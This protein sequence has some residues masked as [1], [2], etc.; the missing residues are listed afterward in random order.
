[1]QSSFSAPHQQPLHVA[2]IMDG[3]GRWATSRRLPREAG[4][5]AGARAVR[6]VV[7]AAHRLGIGTLTLFAFSGDNWHR[8]AREVNH[9]L[10][11]F[12]DY[13]R[14]AKDECVDH[15]I[16][17]SVVGRRDRFPA[18]LLAAAEVAEAATAEG[19]RMRLRI[20]LDYSGRDAILRAAIRLKGN[21]APTPETFSKL[22]AEATNAGSPISDVDLLIR[23]GGEQ[24][25]SDFM[26]WECAYA[27][28][29]FTDR[30]WPDFEAVDLEEALQEF[31]RRER[32]F[33]RI[34]EAVAS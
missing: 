34:S 13:L 23:T 29:I 25:L 7:Q 9:L 33:G 22:L 4:H 21:L 6:G 19:S 5:R 32:R 12:E 11:L 10:G 14:S 16:R 18:S 28:M 2:L 20:A 3:N 26:L 27:E 24:R 15:G 30:M 17:L 31:Y 1:M 8:P